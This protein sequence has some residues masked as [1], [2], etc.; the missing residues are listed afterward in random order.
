[1]KWDTMITAEQA[2][3]LATYTQNNLEGVIENVWREIIRAAQQ[4]LFGTEVTIPTIHGIDLTYYLKGLDYN[5]GAMDNPL[6]PGSHVIMY[7]NWLGHPYTKEIANGK[8][9]NK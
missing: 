8:I 2:R 7:I 9:H 1:M 3:E 4:G 5:I 6:T